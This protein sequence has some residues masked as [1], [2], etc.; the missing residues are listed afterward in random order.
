MWM[1]EAFP[2]VVTAGTTAELLLFHVLHR[3]G[4]PGHLGP[5]F[6][7]NGSSGLT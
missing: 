2:I 7:G 3:E 6:H 1:I 5:S 4:W